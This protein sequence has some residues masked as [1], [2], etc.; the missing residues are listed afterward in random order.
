MPDPMIDRRL[1][2]ARWAVVAAFAVIAVL[3]GTA[4]YAAG[5][6]PGQDAGF[7]DL[8]VVH[9]SGAPAVQ[10]ATVPAI[11]VTVP[12]SGATLA[13][14]PAVTPKAPARSTAAAAPAKTKS[15]S[16]GAAASSNGNTSQ[17]E[18]TVR[19]Q[20]EVVTPDVRVEGS[21]SHQGEGSNEH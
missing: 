9:L 20:R 18:P 17:K 19:K 10:T 3:V 12:K 7:A 8:P 15:G 13:P 2:A 21:G 4:A 14:I 11:T 5:A 6:F 16:A 1:S